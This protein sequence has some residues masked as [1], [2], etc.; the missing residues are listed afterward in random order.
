MKKRPVSHNGKTQRAATVYTAV[1]SVGSNTQL[2]LTSQEESGKK[3][4]GLQEF[5]PSAT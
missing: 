1:Y 3:K 5:Y 4:D 2:V